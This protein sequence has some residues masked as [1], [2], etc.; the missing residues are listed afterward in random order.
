MTANAIDVSK[1][2]TSLLKIPQ[3]RA[4][5]GHGE[6]GGMKISDQ[7]IVIDPLMDKIIKR[8][9]MGADLSLSHIALTSDSN[10]AYIA[11]SQAK[12]IIYKINAKTYEVEVEKQ[13]SAEKGYLTAEETAFDFGSIPMYEGK[14]KHNF[15]LKNTSRATVK[16]SKIY[17]S[18]MCTEVM[19]ITDK[20]RKGPFGMP[21]SWRTHH[22]CQS[23]NRSGG[24]G[25]YGSGGRPG[26]SR[27]ARHRSAKSCLHRNG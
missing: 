25:D 6:E 18:C 13:I 26:R 10:Y 22:L 2:K 4:D 11:T 9:E 14:V 24:R 8:I 5:E 23:R 20:S 27:P 12:G 16:I 17:T 15:T 7:V 19:L 1:N 3:A 21:G